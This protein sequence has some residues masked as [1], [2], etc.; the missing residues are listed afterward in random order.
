MAG[1]RGAEYR[2]TS[3][4][5]ALSPLEMHAGDQCPLLAHSGHGL[6]RCTCPLSGV[7]WTCRFAM[8]MS[9]PMSISWFAMAINP[10]PTKAS[11]VPYAV[12]ACGT[13]P[14]QSGHLPSLTAVSKADIDRHRLPVPK[15]TPAHLLLC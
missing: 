2:C 13:A 6:V 7:K 5:E 8:H 4:S 9:V 14:P 12:S 3:G 1:H 15:A 10:I 11:S